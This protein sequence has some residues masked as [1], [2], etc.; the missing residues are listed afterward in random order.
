MTHPRV[1]V[2]MP[3][4]NQGWFIR[5]AIESIAAQTFRDFE[6]VVVDDGST[7]DT[8]LTLAQF[9]GLRDQWRGI[10]QDNA[11]TAAAINA[12]I[13]VARGDLLTWVSSDNLMLPTWL[14]RLVDHID[15]GAGV[16]Y[17]G[18]WWA[19]MSPDDMRALAPDFAEALH[20]SPTRCSHLIPRHCARYLNTRY[21]PNRQISQPECYLGPSHLIRR[22]VWAPHTHWLAHDLAHFLAVEENCWRAGLPIVNEVDPLCLYFAHDLRRTVT[23]RHRQD[24]RA[25]LE[26]AQTRRATCA[27][28]R[29]N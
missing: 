29:S 23:D 1:S 9:D 4:Y 13:E 7:D 24:A 12:G 3:T 15:A 28:S 8:P 6:L 17:S 10:R 21:D 22:E 2:I 27:E 16:V 11:G 25:I 18:F 14:E 19:P 5:Y 20:H 26:E